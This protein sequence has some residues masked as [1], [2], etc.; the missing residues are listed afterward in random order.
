[1]SARNSC[2]CCGVKG[3]NIRTCP[4]PV[5]RTNLLSIM[6]NAD[7]ESVIEQVNLLE[8]K[9]VP[10]VLV[11]G[12]D[13]AISTIPSV[14][15]RRAVLRQLITEIH[16]TLHP[17]PVV[18]EHPH[19]TI[20]SE[21]E[22]RRRVRHAELFSVMETDSFVEYL[23]GH[24]LHGVELTVEDHAERSAS[25]MREFAS[26]FIGAI[27]SNSVLH[28]R[29]YSDEWMPNAVR[30]ASIGTFMRFP[31][32]AIAHVINLIRIEHYRRLEFDFNDIRQNLFGDDEVDDDV[33]KVLPIRVSIGQF[34]KSTDELMCGVCFDEM[35]VETAVRTG[36]NH[37][38]CSGC[39]TGVAHTRDI[40][41]FIT[42]PCC[43]AEIWHLMVG[44]GEE[45]NAIVAGLEP[46]PI[47]KQNMELL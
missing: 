1:M 26:H 14:H 16:P 6:S 42:C 45:R 32:Q 24:A 47:V 5:A 20:S 40:K 31:T 8:P 18:V 2:C 39:I 22:H 27:L 9:Y 38:F 19:V 11:H 36:C 30:S 28:Q 10:Y 4:D 25:S 3:H 46:I 29:L 37:V 17:P 13:F 41:T 34:N 15:E 35:T 23:P 33:M 44:S 7:L 12:F 21:R 43:R